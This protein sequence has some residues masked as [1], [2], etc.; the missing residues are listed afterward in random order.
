MYIKNNFL[1]ERP[2]A[3]E[4]DDYVPLLVRIGDKPSELYLR[5]RSDYS[6]VELGL[7]AGD[8]ALASIKIVQLPGLSSG[9]MPA[10]SDAGGSGL[11]AF[12]TSFW[13]GKRFLDLNLPVKL[14]LFQ[15][16]A[17]LVLDGV[18]QADRIFRNQFLSFAVSAGYPCWV[19]LEDLTDEQISMIKASVESNSPG[20]FL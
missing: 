20:G 16:S 6:L 13:N 10:Y 1:Q 18:R 19:L 15:G 7:S 11:P 14:I 12:D 4:V 3:L 17:L 9:E 8:G 5:Y 2:L